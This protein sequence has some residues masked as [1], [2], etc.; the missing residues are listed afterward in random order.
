MYHQ[1]S[2]YSL[3]RS[4][5]QSNQKSISIPHRLKDLEKLGVTEATLQHGVPVLRVDHLVTEG[6]QRHV[7]PLEVSLV[8]H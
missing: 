7:R 8:T 5:I 2:Y 4:T 6:S 1:R 3:I